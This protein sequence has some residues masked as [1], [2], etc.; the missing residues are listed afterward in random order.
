MDTAATATITLTHHISSLGTVSQPA[1][2]TTPVNR[3]T[4][5][6]KLFQSHQLLYQQLTLPTALLVYSLILPHITQYHH[7]M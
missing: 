3:P 6:D 5:H 2:F 4:L 7:I 1:V